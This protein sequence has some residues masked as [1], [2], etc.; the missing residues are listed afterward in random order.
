MLIMGCAGSAPPMITAS[1]R[2]L[3]GDKSPMLLAPQ[4]LQ[5]GFYKMI[6]ENI[7]SWLDVLWQHAVFLEDLKIIR[8]LLLRH[9]SVDTPDLVVIQAVDY[10]GNKALVEIG[11]FR[12]EARRVGKEF[13]STC[14]SRGTRCI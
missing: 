4:L 10:V 14:R 3:S 5:G 6:V 2:L 1:S 11:V 8:N 13:V 12:S 9:A 7:G